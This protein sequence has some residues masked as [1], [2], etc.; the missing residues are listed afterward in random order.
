MTAPTQMLRFATL[1]TVLLAGL[2][3]AQAPQRW[4]LVEIWR[5][6]GDIGRQISFDDVVDMELAANG[7]LLVLVGGTSGQLLVIDNTGRRVRSI[8]SSTSESPDLDRPNGVVQMNDGRI[9]V[10]DPHVARL[11]ELTAA[12]SF[13]RYVPYDRWGYMFRWTA[14]VH[15]DGGL[16]EPFASDGQL[17]WRRWSPDLSTSD[18]L[19]STGCDFG[20]MRAAPEAGFEMRS[21]SGAATFLPV[22][23]LTPPVFIARNDAGDTWTGIGPAYREIVRTPWRG[24]DDLAT[25]QL[26]GDPVPVPDDVYSTAVDGIRSAAAR[27]GAATPDLE[28]IPHVRPPFETLR[29]DRQ[30]RLWVERFTIG[31]GR[32]FTVYSREGRPLAHV[33]VEL[34]VVTEKPSAFNDNH[35]FYFTRDESGWLWL[36]AMRIERVE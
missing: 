35:F 5:S 10:N 1:C 9:I 31:Q 17:V 7:H 12:G 21:P 14:F 29:I 32:D 20:L 36:M 6:G 22:P 8:G 24:C 30:D 23:F 25:I 34:P 19:P 18:L 11:T 3:H 4:R 13:I 28:R 2:L 27:M 16:Y 15:E 33:P 26:E